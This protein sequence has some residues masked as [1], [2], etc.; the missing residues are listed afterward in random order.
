MKKIAV[1]VDL[2]SEEAKTAIKY[3]SLGI[4]DAIQFHKIPYESVS[5]ELLSLPHIFATDSL[6]EYEKLVSKG[7]FRV[8]FDSESITQGKDLAQLTSLTYELKWLA[9]GITPENAPSLIEQYHP[10]LIDVSGGI[11]DTGAPGI[12]NHNKLQKLMEEL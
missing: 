3:V 10:E 7:E 11:E 4:L 1:I 5:N 8:L 9:G 12:K 6:E 2:D